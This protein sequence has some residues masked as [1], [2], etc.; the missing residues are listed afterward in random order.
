MTRGNYR[1]LI[2]AAYILSTFIYAINLWFSVSGF[3]LLLAT[4]CVLLLVIFNKKRQT[5]VKIPDYKVL[6]VFLLLIFAG[7]SFTNNVVDINGELSLAMW[8][9]RFSLFLICLGP[10]LYLF[11]NPKNLIVKFFVLRKY[12]VILLLFL[13]AQI[14]ILRIV[15]VPDIDVYQVLRYGPMQLLNLKNPYVTPASVPQL[16]DIGF[17][18]HHYAYG[19]TTIYLLLPFD[20]ILKEPRYLLIIASFLTVFCIYKIARKSGYG[21]EIAQLLSLIFLA[22]PRFIYFLTYSLTDGLIVSLIALG[23]L[24]YVNGEKTF[25]AIAL[26]LALGIKIFYVFPYLFFMKLYELRNPRFILSG[27]ST[28]IFVH[29]PFLIN[30][31]QAMYQS[32]VVLNTKPEF[33]TMLTRSSLTFATLID[34]QFHTFPASNFFIIMTVALVLLLWLILPIANNIY[35]TLIMVSFVFMVVIFFGPIANANY[36]FAASTLLLFAFASYGRLKAP[37]E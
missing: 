5:D 10:L 33:Q 14:T 21:E 25:M 23:L 27:L 18:Y 28:V 2:L 12:F 7:F 32:I 19:P 20:L 29:L 36:Y 4:L 8:V 24:F 30:N 9:N 11:E 13:V 16:E 35:R 17:N 37:D 3:Y 26:G 6:L 22:N 1:F 15:R 34:R 31:W